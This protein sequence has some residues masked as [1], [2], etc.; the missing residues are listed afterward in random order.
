M[1]SRDLNDPPP[2]QLLFKMGISFL[3]I[4]TKAVKEGDYKY[5]INMGVSDVNDRGTYFRNPKTTR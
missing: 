2:L 3:F 4:W 5:C 1:A